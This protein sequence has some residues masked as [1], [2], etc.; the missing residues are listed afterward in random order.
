MTITVKFPESFD[1]VFFSNVDHISSEKYDLVAHDDPIRTFLPSSKSFG[2]IDTSLLP[3]YSFWV[4]RN[5]R[6]PPIIYEAA[7]LSSKWPITSVIV[8]K[9]KVDLGNVFEKMRVAYGAMMK[10]FHRYIL[11]SREKSVELRSID[12]L[13]YDTKMVSTIYMNDKLFNFCYVSHDGFQRDA[14]LHIPHVADMDAV[15]HSFICGVIEFLHSGELSHVERHVTVDTLAVLADV[16]LYMSAQFA[17][18]SGLVCAL[19]HASRVHRRP[20]FDELRA[21]L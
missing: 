1:D 14:Y 20:T 19:S 15:I 9:N 12:T 16:T 2:D 5:Q 3:A 7:K 10:D 21:L 17:I 6:S 11:N 4:R 8:L 18:P 13:T